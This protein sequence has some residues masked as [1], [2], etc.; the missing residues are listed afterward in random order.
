MDKKKKILEIVHLIC[1]SD[2]CINTVTINS[3]KDLPMISALA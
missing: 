1:V 2:D 3:C